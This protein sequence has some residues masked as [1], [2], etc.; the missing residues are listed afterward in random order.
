MNRTAAAKWEE[1]L[2]RP[3]TGFFRA[4][5]ALAAGSGGG[6]AAAREAVLRLAPLPPARWDV[7]QTRASRV[8]VP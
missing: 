8:Q 1:E 3:T 5:A 7:V 4:F 2:D 6:E